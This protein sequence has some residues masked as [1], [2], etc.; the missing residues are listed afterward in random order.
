V[1]TYYPF[2]PNNLQTFSFTPFFD[3]NQYFCT[4]TWNLFGQRY[5]VNCYDTQNNLVFTIPLITNP[6]SLNIAS[7]SWSPASLRAT[8]TTV[9]PHGLKIGTVA[10]L[11]LTG[12]NPSTY[13]GEFDCSVTSANSFFYALSADPGAV[14]GLGT[15]SFIISM[16]R[17]YFNSTLVFRN[18]QLEVNP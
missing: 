5:Y 3:G 2:A 7:L 13:D 11:T 15:A 16:T 14:I 6:K 10:R 1:T 8:V 17:G 12:D 18:G 9:N 4:V